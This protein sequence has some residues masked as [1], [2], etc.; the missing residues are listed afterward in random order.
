MSENVTGKRIS[1]AYLS[2]QR[3][4]PMTRYLT[5]AVFIALGTV[6]RGDAIPT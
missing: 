4:L 6:A 2:D 5:A 1:N 3:S